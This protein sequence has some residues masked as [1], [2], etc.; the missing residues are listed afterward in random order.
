MKWVDRTLVSRAIDN[1]VENALRF[2]PSDGTVEV[3]LCGDGTFEV[4]DQGPGVPTEL[5]ATVFDKY[6]QVRTEHASH[7]NRGLGLTLVQLAARAHGGDAE[8]VGAEGGGSVFRV[9]F[10]PAGQ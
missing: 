8:V 9:S 4:V 1:L 7:T 6:V 10:Q 2:S 5:R 3:R